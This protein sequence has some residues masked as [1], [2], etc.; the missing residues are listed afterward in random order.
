MDNRAKHV[1]SR[2]SI[3]SLAARDIAR[4]N[5]LINNPTGSQ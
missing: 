2:H 5:K 3:P 4:K 1:E